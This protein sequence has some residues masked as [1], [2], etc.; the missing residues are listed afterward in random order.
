MHHYKLLGALQLAAAV[1]GPAQVHAEVI[2]DRV[3]KLPGHDLGS[4]F[5]AMHLINTV[6]NHPR[7]G[8]M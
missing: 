7:T 6:S 2:A 4:R 8:L 1:L 5:A 3:A